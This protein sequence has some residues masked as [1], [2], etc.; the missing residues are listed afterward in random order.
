[1]KFTK[2]LPADVEGDLNLI[3][4]RIPS[5]WDMRTEVGNKILEKIKDLIIDE[6][7]KL[8]EVQE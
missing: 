6:V 5:V 3:S 7:K 8:P 2:K 1:M 4:N